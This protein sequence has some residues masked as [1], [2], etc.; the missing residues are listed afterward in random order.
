MADNHYAIAI[1]GPAASGK[2]TLA[3]LLAEQLQI[4]FLS[5]GETYRAA[6]W[7]ALEKNLLLDDGHAIVAAMQQEPLELP[8]HGTRTQVTAAGRPLADELRSD[9]VNAA[10]SKVAALP[11]VRRYLVELQRN[12][13]AQRSVVI[14]GRDIGTV[15][16]AD[17][18]YKFFIDA[19]SEIRQQRR[20]AQGQ[21]DRVTDRDRADSSRK[22]SPLTK[23][24]DAIT[25][26]TTHLTIA[27]ALN[28][29]LDRLS[30]AGITID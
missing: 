13:A 14:E 29:I 30:V 17:T 12:A 25:I 10:V 26:D 23:A 5:T 24:A 11:E 22:E 21:G 18:P 7:L 19:S 16:L 28:Q 4:G 6:T 3:E 20:T 9:A 8:W 27:E 15:V 1:D 2:S